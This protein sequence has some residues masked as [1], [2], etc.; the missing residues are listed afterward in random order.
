MAMPLNSSWVDR[1]FGRLAIRYG[2]AFVRQWPDLDIDAVKADWADVLDGMP[3]EAIGYALSYLPD[4][5]P[6]ASQFKALCNRRPDKAPPMLPAPKADPER[7]RMLLEGIKR[8][9]DGERSM[10]EGVVKELRARIADGQKLTASQRYVLE[11]CEK[12]VSGSQSEGAVLGAFAGI[13]AEALPP[14]MRAE[15]R[16]A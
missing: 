15:A 14:A 2:A 9:Q 4:T 12:H 1:I 10:A 7:V 16:A 5:P 6:N 8:G 13:P 11:C 3:G